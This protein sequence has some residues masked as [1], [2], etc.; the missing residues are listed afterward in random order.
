MSNIHDLAHFGQSIWYDNIS[1]SIL[2]SGYMA[3][4]IDLGI[5][6]VT[7]NPAIFKKA[8]ADSADYDDV[9]RALAAAGT[10]TAD[11]Y[12]ALALAD[13]GRAADLFAPVYAASDGLDGYV[14]LE[15]NPALAHDAAG[16][17][18]EARR[19]FAALD[20]PNVMIKVPATPAGVVAFETLI[21]AGINVNVTLMFSLS[22][23]EDIAQAYIRGLQQLAARGGDLRRVAAVASFFVSRIDTAVDAALSAAGEDALLGKI[24]IANAKL[25][26]GRFQDIGDSPAWQELAAQGARPQRLL[27]ASTST[28]NPAYPDTIYVDNLI[29]P[30]TV[31]TMP[32]A[33]V[34][35]FLDHGTLAE[36]LTADVDEAEE[37]IAYLDDLDIDFN[38]ITQ[39]LQDDGVQAFADAFRA[40]LAAL[41]AKQAAL[42]AA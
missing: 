22:H 39:Q 14:S 3:R 13:I 26:Y 42:Q 37:Q 10:P 20:R 15:V 6:G 38:A 30:Q 23:Y 18:A 8:I 2:D 40:L 36:T 7:S 9:I 28:K 12:E 5:V 1:R 19:L 25:A 24:A 16:T 32:P 31:N 34:D 29:G 4:L 33:T 41:E 35:A 27:W 11:L 21:A 17:V